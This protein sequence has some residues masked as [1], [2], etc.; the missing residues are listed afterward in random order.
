M[1]HPSG[2][3]EPP[4][5][6]EEGRRSGF[7]V[8]FL[9]TW[10]GLVAGLLDVLAVHL[11]RDVFHA[12]P[13]YE[14]GRHFHWVVPLAHLAV[15]MLPGLVLAGL[16]GL[17]PAWISPRLAAWSLGSLALWG[18]LLRAP[19]H[20]A[21]GL[22]LA[23]GLA[24]V[25]SGPLTSRSPRTRRF[26]RFSAG[27]LLVLV[28]VVAA[29]SIGWERLAKSR[30]LARLPAPPRG[31]KNVLLLVMDTVRARSLGL[32]GYS[33]DTTPNLA[34]WARRGVRFDWAV[35][36]APWTFPSHCTIL[37]GQWPSMLN[38]L[39]QPTLDAPY[40]TLAEFLS[41]RGYETAGFVGNTKFCSYESRMNRGF[42]HYEDYPLTPWGVLASI[43]SGRWL[44]AWGLALGDSYETKWIDLQSRDARG[45][46]RALRDWI[47]NRHGRGR[48]F[49]AFLNYMDAHEPFVPPPSGVPAIAPRPKSA[50]DYKMLMD[51][52]HADKLAL[53]KSDVRMA[54]DSYDLCIAA[55]DQQI[56][57]LLDELDRQGLLRDTLVIVTAD[58]GEEFGEHGV[59]THGFSVYATEIHVPLLVIDP[60]APQGRSVSRPV[61]LRD[62]PAT[63]VD[64]LGV[65][66]AP[67]PGK[68]LAEHWRTA[69]GTA[70]LPVSDPRSEVDI[71]R[72][73][74]RDRGYGPRQRGF[75]MSF[76]ADV[77]HYFVGVE[78]QEEL[79]DV[80]IDPAEVRNLAKDPVLAPT[81]ALLRSSV[82]NRLRIPQAPNG[83]AQDARGRLRAK[84][85]SLP[86]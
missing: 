64:L 18:P 12:G 21:A 79:Y 52:W 39:W 83:V 37:T 61:S 15:V 49:F 62:L 38:V 60:T 32:Y 13:Y 9:A 20:G 72:E 41:S 40:P 71:P 45:L 82:L 10:F 11:K 8:L 6:P 5:P 69:A 51:Y 50:R 33:R 25:L 76:V 3:V 81:L 4:G 19:V 73:V 43:P 75:T 46:H 57:S 24:R 77:L 35:A 44:L 59:Y 78:G 85:E 14:Q 22:L 66:P 28:V 80:S 63:V 31:A 1:P 84:L 30:T 53:P 54:R 86:R 23:A 47:A 7:D 27:G 29:G 55:L 70:S 2:T 74:G 58:H 65:G 48:P 68:S 67:F 16:R 42:L 56:G 36:S 26:V 34:R 17:R